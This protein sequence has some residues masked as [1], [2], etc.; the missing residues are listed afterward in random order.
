MDPWLVQ[1]RD[2]A[3]TWKHYIFINA[4][5]SYASSDAPFC[6]LFPAPILKMGSYVAPS[7]KAIIIHKSEKKLVFLRIQRLFQSKSQLEPVKIITAAVQDLRTQASAICKIPVYQPRKET[8]SGHSFERYWPLLSIFLHRHTR[9]P[10]HECHQWTHHNIYPWTP[11]IVHCRCS[12]N[13]EPRPEGTIIIIYNSW[14]SMLC[15]QCTVRRTAKCAHRNV[16]RKLLVPALSGIE[17]TH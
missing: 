4:V 6:T 5:C 14:V 1:D 16:R 2:G 3:G 17:L 15:A 8:Y 10:L 13:D 12:R 7:D 9:W 11:M